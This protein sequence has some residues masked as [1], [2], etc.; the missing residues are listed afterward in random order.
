MHLITLIQNI[1]NVVFLSGQT[2][3]AFLPP[4]LRTN[5]GHIVSMNSTLGMMGLA[6]AADYCASKY[7]CRYLKQTT[8]FL[9][10]S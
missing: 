10:D 6:S 4:M 7:A 5:H 2:I 9:H 8:D 3:K 1:F